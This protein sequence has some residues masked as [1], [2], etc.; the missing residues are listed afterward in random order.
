MA[1]YD[2]I[3]SCGHEERIELLGAVKD[4][5]RKIEY[6]R[7]QGLCSECYKKQRQAKQRIK[8]TIRMKYAEY[9]VKD[10][11]YEAIKDTYDADDKTIEVMLKDLYLL[12]TSIANIQLVIDSAKV[13]KYIVNNKISSKDVLKESDYYTAYPNLDGKPIKDI[14][15]SL[16]AICSHIMAQLNIKDSLDV[17]I[18]SGKLVQCKS[19]E[20]FYSIKE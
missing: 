13:V 10:L 14:E 18:A 17:S 9:K 1:K 7:E 15:D 19:L 12:E 8:P 6:F 4:R 16:Q 3:F 20:E 5:E 2:V 11:I